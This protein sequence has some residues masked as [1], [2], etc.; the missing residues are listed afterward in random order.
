M[1]MN[2]AL[3]TELM[4]RALR[5]E[6][7]GKGGYRFDTAKSFGDFVLLVNP[8]FEGAAYEAL[9]R[10]GLVTGERTVYRNG[11]LKHPLERTCTVTPR[12][13]LARYWDV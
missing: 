3:D 7:E 5:I 11:T 9:F 4:E 12:C 6:R 2:H 1:L 13:D 8:A 10:K